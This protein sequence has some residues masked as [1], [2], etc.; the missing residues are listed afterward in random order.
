MLIRRLITLFALFVLAPHIAI[1]ADEALLHALLIEKASNDAQRKLNAT[2]RAEDARII[3]APNIVQE[4]KR[5]NIDIKRLDAHTQNALAGKKVIAVMISKLEPLPGPLKMMSA[6]QQ[7]IAAYWE[8]EAREVEELIATGGGSAGGGGHGDS[9][10][11]SG[12]ATGCSQCT[13]TWTC[14]DCRKCQ[15]RCCQWTLCP[16]GPPSCESVK[17]QPESCAC[18]SSGTSGAPS[19]QTIPD[20]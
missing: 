2:F 7:M 15:K 11:T 9:S 19:S 4:L 6:D 16:S 12:S 17:C 10:G 1:G 5:M 18:G 20:K 3:R 8:A 14:S 13:T